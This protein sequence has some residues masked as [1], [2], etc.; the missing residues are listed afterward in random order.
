ML[1]VHIALINH[2]GLFFFSCM[3]NSAHYAIIV[4]IGAGGYVTCK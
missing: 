4:V 3:A 2:I 1:S